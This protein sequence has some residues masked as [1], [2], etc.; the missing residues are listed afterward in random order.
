M[1]FF[2]CRCTS[3]I[4]ERWRRC[5]AP[6]A[7]SRLWPRQ[8]HSY[9]HHRYCPTRISST[10][11]DVLYSVWTCPFFLQDQGSPTHQFLSVV[12]QTKYPLGT[13]VQLSAFIINTLFNALVGSTYGQQSQN[14]IS[15][16]MTIWYKAYRQ[17]HPQVWLLDG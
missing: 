11:S 1:H 8:C 13:P 5:S 10:A 12:Q 15:D 14:S 17:V 6:L 2:C 16:K 3:L 4:W 9:S 7:S